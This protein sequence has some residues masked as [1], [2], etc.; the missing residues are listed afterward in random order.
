M[1]GTISLAKTGEMNIA[2]NYTLNVYLSVQRM[3]CGT[4]GK[5][6][7]NG[8]KE[9]KKKK[10]RFNILEQESTVWEMRPWLGVSWE[11]WRMAMGHH[12]GNSC[13]GNGEQDMALFIWNLT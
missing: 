10:N 4:K 9:E 7:N 12:M 13:L 5:L 3:V 6:N 1:H 8:R 11:M 2:S